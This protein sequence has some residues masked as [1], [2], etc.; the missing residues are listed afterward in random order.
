M[1]VE[2]LDL[3]FLFLKAT[4]ATCPV[5][6]ITKPLK[7]IPVL[8]TLDIFYSD[9]LRSK[10]LITYH[11]ALLKIHI[12]SRVASIVTSLY[13]HSNLNFTSKMLVLVSSADSPLNGSWPDRRT[14]NRTPKLQIS[15][16]GKAWASSR[17]S[18]AKNIQ[19]KK[20]KYTVFDI[21]LA[22]LQK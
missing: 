6:L 17:I 20:Y 21:S 10:L 22:T 11:G 14:Y 8:F 5:A 9:F 19:N 1:Q 13:N 4:Y 2:W 16:C 3:A 12:K 15:D 18:G 7:F